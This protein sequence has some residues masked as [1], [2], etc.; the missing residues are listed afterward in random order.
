MLIC[1]ELLATPE[2]TCSART[3]L[4]IYSLTP[5]LLAKTRTEGGEVDVSNMSGRPWGLGIHQGIA[6]NTRCLPEWL[7][8][9]WNIQSN[10]I[11][12]LSI[13]ISP[14]DG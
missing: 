8:M 12:C 6:N 5:L 11:T 9:A 13:T 10:E 2:I 14:D 7:H 1:G 4:F 3:R